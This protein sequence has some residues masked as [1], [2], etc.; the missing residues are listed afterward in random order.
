MGRKEKNQPKSAATEKDTKK[1][2]RRASVAEVKA[3]ISKKLEEVEKPSKSKCTLILL[4]FPI[5]LVGVILIFLGFSAK[6]PENFKKLVK[7]LHEQGVPGP[8][9]KLMQEMVK[10]AVIFSTGLLLFGILVGAFSFLGCWGAMCSKKF[11]KLYRF[12]L[13][14]VFLLIAGLGYLA[15]EYIHGRSV[16]IL[17]SMLSNIFVHYN[18]PQARQF[19]FTI[20]LEGK[21]CG[22]ISPA[23][24]ISDENGEGIYYDNFYKYLENR[25][26]TEFITGSDPVPDSCCTRPNLNCGLRNNDTE[27]RQAL[28]QVK[29]HM[30]G[31]TE[32]DDQKFEEMF[33]DLNEETDQLQQENYDPDA[34]EHDYE[35]TEYADYYG[36]DVYDYYDD[37]GEFDWDKYKE[38][39]GDEMYY[40][41]AVTDF[42]YYGYDYE[43]DDGQDYQVS[44]KKVPDNYRIKN[45]DQLE[46]PNS[47]NSDSN[48]EDSEDDQENNQ[49]PED[50]HIW[51]FGCAVKYGKLLER[52]KLKVTILIGILEIPVLLCIIMATKVI[53]Y[54]DKEDEKKQEENYDN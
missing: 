10:Q 12:L 29:D 11:L 31:T 5:F 6:S 9:I 50:M 43:Q 25:N 37:Y 20:Q 42:Y 35:D 46:P 36:H 8:I 3:S 2:A 19:I 33:A 23:D 54:F 51:K 7:F 18:H 49:I 17:A 13:I 14:I 26:K 52:N 39:N 30:W 1:A 32:E 41:Y 4:N 44:R 21:C 24:W 34:F 15:Y 28:E 53:K 48:S 16:F 47:R 45:R 40:Y 38:N 22:G 27:H